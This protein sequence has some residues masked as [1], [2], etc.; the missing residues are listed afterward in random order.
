M[1]QVTAGIIE[2]EDK[3]LLARR[4]EGKHLAGYWE[5]PGGKIET[6][7]SPEECLKRELQEEFSILSE[8]GDFVAESVF[9]YPGKIISLK[10][11]KVKLL[12][13]DFKL[14]DH[15]K[16]E[17]VKPEDVMTYLLAPADVPI[18]EAYDKRRLKK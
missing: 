12:S 4:R 18:W 15:D 3:I 8:V 6:G 1:I 2:N 5:F 14:I 10:A 9:S 11:Y 13:G 7:E 17:W 16:V